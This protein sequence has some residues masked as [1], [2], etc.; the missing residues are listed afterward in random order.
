MNVSNTV[1]L[2]QLVDDVRVVELNQSCCLVPTLNVET[3][4]SLHDFLTVCSCYH[5]VTHRLA[6]HRSFGLTKKN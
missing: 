5:T 3:C 6:V 2:H 4:Y 1:D